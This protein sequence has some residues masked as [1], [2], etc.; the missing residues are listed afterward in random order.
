MG[1]E[2]MLKEMCLG[3]LEVRNWGVELGENVGR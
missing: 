1:G 2:I 3:G